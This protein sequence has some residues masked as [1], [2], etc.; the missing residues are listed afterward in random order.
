MKKY[1]II[2]SL[3][4]VFLITI[5]AFANAK[6]SPEELLESGVY[7]AEVKGELQDAIKIFEQILA[8]HSQNRAVAA[9]ALLHLGSSYQKLGDQKAEGTYQRLISEFGDQ[10]I[11]VS[12]ARIRLQKIKY[13]ELVNGM[14]VSDSGPNN[15]LALD[16]D[17]P[18]VHPL[19]GNQFDLSPDG[20]RIVYQ[21]KE[22]LYVSDNTGTLRHRIV[23]HNP[24]R[25]QWQVI[26][27]HVGQ[28][29]WSPDGKWIAYLT[30]KRQVS[31]L[32]DDIF[33]LALVS[34][35]GK[36]NRLLSSVLDPP[37][38]GGFCWLPDGSGLTYLSTEGMSTIDL[39]G[40]MVRTFKGNFNWSTRLLEYSPD[41][42]W[43][44]FQEK[45]A[46]HEDGNNFE[47]D[48][49]VIPASG[50]DPVWI[51]QSAG[52]NGNPTWSA[53][54]RTIYFVSMR[55]KDWN[56]WKVS[57]D[58]QSG[59]ADNDFEQMTFLTDARIMYPNVVGDNDK[60]LY[61]LKKKINTVHVADV[62]DPKT[63]ATLARGINPSLSPDGKMIYY[64]GEGSQEKDQGIFAVASD[65][66]IPQ[67]LTK[68]NPA[69][70]LKDLSPD[71]K[72]LAY[73]SNFENGRGLFV[74]SVNGGDP[75]LLM[76]NECADCSTAPRWSP[77]GKK[78]AYTY[79]DGL[80]TISSSGGASKKL[81]TLYGWES[82]TVRW[83]PDG[84]HIAA[85]AYGKANEENAVY[86]V[87]AEG[88]DARLLSGN[89]M[90]YK[91]GL[92]WTPDGQSLVYHLS[93]KNSR[94]LKTFLDGRPPELFL[95]K[96]DSWDYFGVWAPDGKSY[97]FLNSS[98]SKSWDLDILD[99]ES[100]EFTRFATNADLPSWSADGNT[101]AWTTEIAIQQLWLMEDNK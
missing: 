13:D 10:R 98:P 48:I 63:Y 35:D 45:T 15:R 61:A 76:K 66:G 59:K 91:E 87:P 84:K 6:T 52:F 54:G 71:G 20:E 9:Q 75:K 100:G 37:P 32:D 60:I 93:R 89:N 21:G 4:A 22:G 30:S 40:K 39:D 64:V 8:K 92:E 49:Y 23:A 96:P 81:S 56:I 57:F 41:G 79:K 73:F 77:D 26:W 19:R 12:E 7:K 43:L 69:A 42:R 86:V 83:S 74:V 34:P 27:I 46:G 95:D 88:G 85:L 31:D 65:N 36:Q 47:T 25:F 72:R 11:A 53:D 44:I 17:S 67:R 80:Y 94:I 29:R 18:D 14:Q 28:P 38:I 50:G 3:V 1:Q 55:T 78:L 51:T 33:K 90:D 68:V 99:T 101:I 24:D 58:T 62:A 70:A 16:D 5:F 82:W 97:F 2:I